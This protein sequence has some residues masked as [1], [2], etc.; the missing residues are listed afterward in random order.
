[1]TQHDRLEGLLVDLREA[2]SK[3]DEARC[4]SLAAFIKEARRHLELE[5]AI[6]YPTVAPR[7]ILVE[8]APLLEEHATLH[9]GLDRLEAAG[10]AGGSEFDLAWEKLHE[11]LV[12]HLSDEEIELFP[13]VRRRFD[14]DEL[15]ALGERMERSLEHES[16]AE[17]PVAEPAQVQQDGPQQPTPDQP[18]H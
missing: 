8:A 13:E 3:G 11:Q 1:M 18:Q 9:I 10:Q 16:P 2:A 12:I 5:S 17:Q 7:L 15:D 14:I 4:P 6:F